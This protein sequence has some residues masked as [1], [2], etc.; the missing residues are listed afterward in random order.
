M[1]YQTVIVPI[2]GTMEMD[3]Q[4]RFGTVDNGKKDAWGIF[5]PSNIRIGLVM[6]RSKNYLLVS[7]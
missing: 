3:I 5:A 1:D 7:G 4:H 6:R 2:K